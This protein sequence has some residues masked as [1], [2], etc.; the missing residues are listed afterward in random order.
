MLEKLQNTVSLKFSECAK[1]PKWMKHSM[2]KR[3]I[4][5]HVAP[6]PIP[7]QG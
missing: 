4:G 2:N 7:W 5:G 1:M 3:I 6:S